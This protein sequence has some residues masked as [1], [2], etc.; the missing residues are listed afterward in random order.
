VASNELRAK[1][2]TALD[3]RWTI[4][5]AGGVDKIGSFVALF[6]GNELDVAVLT[7]FHDGD[8]KKV[9]SLRD[10]E[11]LRSGTSLPRALHRRDRGGR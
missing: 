5:P 4:T 7:D 2:K 11:L 1:G 9:R 3:P 10:S 8:K 6:R